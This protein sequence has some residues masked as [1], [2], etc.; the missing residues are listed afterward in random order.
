MT[1]SNKYTGIYYNE[2]QNGD[3]AYYITYKDSE[4]KM[5]RIKIGLHSAGVREAFCKQKRDEIL[6]NQRLGEEPPAIATRKKSTSLKFSEVWEKYIENKA[7]V[8]AL[9]NDFRGRYNRYMSPL[10]GTEPANTL[11]KDHLK[12]FREDVQKIAKRKDPKGN[13]LL[14]PRSV[15]IMITVIGTAYNY[16]NSTVTNEKDK[17]VNPVPS[18]R[19]DD[20]QHVTKQDMQKRDVRRERFL[21][22][23]EILLL[24][25]AVKDI[26][27]V[28][29]FVAISLSTGARLSSVLAIQKAHIDMETRTIT[30]INTKAGG[31]R[32]NGFINDELFDLL[33]NRLSNIKPYQHVVSTDGNLITD[34]II[35]RPLQ[36]ILNKLF[37]EGLDMRDT[38][39][40]V[41]IHTLRHTFASHLAIAGTPIITIKTLLDHKD[42]A[43]TMRYAKLMPDAGSDA[44][45]GLNL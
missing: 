12:K 44:V 23:D 5:K 42:I 3:K 18:L 33:K 29:L 4:A 20:R 37:N 26:P 25:E 24:K 38:A 36:R 41:V 32:Y 40:R 8:D 13:A 6:N 21:K 11:N 17:L 45:R 19:A 34:R 9:R 15:D 30:L 2:L 1:K 39:N 10:I 27:L 31:S 28:R 35:Q 7:M 22:R 43:T 14:S 16:W